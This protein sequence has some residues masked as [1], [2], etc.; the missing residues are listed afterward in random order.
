MANLQLHRYD[1]PV[2][3]SEIAVTVIIQNNTKID[4]KAI[5]WKSVNWIYLQED[6][7][8][9]GLLWT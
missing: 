9:G 6:E 2:V 4:L 3:H 7:P 8:T 1:P 5:G